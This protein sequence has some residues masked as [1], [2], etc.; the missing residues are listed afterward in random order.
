MSEPTA[1]M[2]RC[3][4]NKALALRIARTVADG[5]SP[6]SGEAFALL[7]RFAATGVGASADQSAAERNRRFAW[8]LGAWQPGGEPFAD[9]AA[10]TAFLAS[11]ET[12]ALLRAKA[13]PDWALQTRLHLARALLARGGTADLVEAGHVAAEPAIAALNEGKVLA[14]RLALA[15]GP[16]PVQAS[17]ATAMLRRAAIGPPGR[18]E[19]DDARA[20]LL[21]VARRSLAT[22]HTDIERWDTIRDLALAAFAGDEEALGIFR[23]AVARA[24]GG[25]SPATLSKEEARLAGA[26]WRLRPGIT[27]EDYPSGALRAGTQGDVQL[28]VLIDPLGRSIYTEAMGSGQDAVLVEATR[29][30]Y[31]SRLTGEAI[32]PQPR[33]TLYI[34]A[35]LQAISFRTGG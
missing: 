9:R 22:A 1:P 20:A 25:K 27:S 26:E 31:A 7:A 16:S 32:L 24:N 23:G 30:I 34:W 13:K 5:P 17:E 35:P 10:R 29:R 18:W 2:L 28:R 8:L 4:E 3:K 21:A 12:I 11:P 15:G 19:G 33:P 14:A 6:A